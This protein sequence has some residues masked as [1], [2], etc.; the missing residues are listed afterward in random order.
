[1]HL[2]LRFTNSPNIYKSEDSHEKFLKDVFGVPSEHVL[3]LETLHH[4]ESKD[5]KVSMFSNKDLRLLFL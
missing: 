5:E 3:P 1:M 2:L 4:L